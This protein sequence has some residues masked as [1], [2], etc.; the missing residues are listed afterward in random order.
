M[1]E[2]P[3]QCPRCGAPLPADAPEGICPKCLV[4]LGLSPA[5]DVG[6]G[7]TE[8]MPREPRPP[9][10]VSEIAP[11]FPQLEILEC[12]GRGGMGVVYK[13]RQP[14]LNRLAALKILAR[15]KEKD[16]QFTERFLRE[17]QA[18]ARLNHPNIVTVYD[19]GETDGLCYLLMEFVD[20]T[21]LREVLR[22]MKVLPENALAIV[23]RICDALQYAHEQGV[24]HRDIKPEN[25]LID[26]QGRVKIA[27]FG[28]AKIVGEAVPQEPLTREQHAIGTPHYMAPEQVEKP[29]TV[30]HRADIYSLGVV[31]YEMLT[32]E[33][34]LGK[35]AVPSKKVQVDVRL[36]EVVLHALEKE[37]ERR[38]QQASQVKRDVETIA[39]TG[40]GAQAGAAAGKASPRPFAVAPATGQGPSVQ[41]RFSRAAIV[42]ALFAPFFLF[43]LAGF[44]GVSYHVIRPGSQ[45][46]IYNWF[47]IFGLL[48]II[49]L[50]VIGV[51]APVVT[52]VCGFVA[53]SQIRHS[54]GRLY[55]LGLA[56]FDALLFPL[57]LLDV[58]IYV[59]WVQILPGNVL[60]FYRAAFVTGTVVAMDILAVWLVWWAA[61]RP[62]N[63]DAA[64]SARMPVAPDA[65]LAPAAVAAACFLIWTV[66]PTFL[67]SLG[68]RFAGAFVAITGLFLIGTVVLAIA[69]LTQIRNSQGRLYGRPLAWCSIIGAPL[70]GLLLLVVV[71]STKRSS[72]PYFTVSGVTVNG[73]GGFVQPVAE[74][75]INATPSPAVSPA[76]S[77]ENVENS[78]AAP[79]RAPPELPHPVPQ[80]TVPAQVHASLKA[81]YEAASAMRQFSSR[82]PVMAE[83]AGDAAKAGD[84]E[85]VTNALAGMSMFTSRDQAGAAAARS[86]LNLGRPAAALAAADK[87]TAFGSRD[88]VLADIAKA[89]AT[90]GQVDMTKETLKKMTMFTARDEAAR[91]VS[92]LLA[93]AGQRAGAV[94]VARG[95]MQMN[96]RDEALADLAK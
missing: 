83:I 14:K 4:R 28:I 23:P 60:Y 92:L 74:D 90:A 68:G 11:H 49:P 52:T 57:L 41:R 10:L 26:K 88:P 51:V 34:P 79:V 61:R 27:D 36:D 32:G 39:T 16:Q 59:L 31:F 91:A 93:R 13:A 37:P 72:T 58:I 75:N 46:I 50:S 76:S 7:E 62:S 54:A 70:L 84:V 77:A 87:M 81:R 44:F 18:L 96:V 69:A 5:T 9:P 67:V 94:E 12:L 20:G 2:A 43:V 55:G 3:K 15:E 17:A 35:F 89:F 38:Y 80:P 45:P 29:G 71:D 63:G 66:V 6:A 47:R 48:V 1:A 33:L 40:A 78:E 73:P 22:T 82:D 24:V 53:I 86:L 65:K 42:G 19:Y 95:I 21:N 30:D 56:V 8:L 64:N 25:I 85:M